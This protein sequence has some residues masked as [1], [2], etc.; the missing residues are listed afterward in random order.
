MTFR[1]KKQH[2]NIAFAAFKWVMAIALLIFGVKKGLLDPSQWMEFI[3]DPTLILLSLAFQMAILLAHTARWKVLND[4]IGS[5]IPF[6]KLYQIQMISH[7]FSI[8]LAG[9]VGADIVR[10]LYASRLEKES[11][12]RSILTIVLDR[13][14]GLGILLLIAF[15]GLVWKSGF[16]PET[17]RIGQAAQFAS[18]IA[19]W[20]ALGLGVLV[21]MGIRF[22][23][24]VFLSSLYLSLLSSLLTVAWIYILGK[25]LGIP[26]LFRDYL[27]MVPLAIIA[28]AI[29]ILPLGIGVGQIAY[30]Q[31]F[32]ILGTKGELGVSLCTLTQF[33]I[34]LFNLIGV[35]YYLKYRK[36]ASNPL[37]N[38]QKYQLPAA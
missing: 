18:N 5:S 4:K 28:S 26:L 31:L 25:Y 37:P 23:G 21:F 15:S 13:G 20:A 9:S 6:K 22:F 10:G 38:K 33:H 17:L 2:K 24:K 1:I 19:P 14:A 12:V 32:Q 29:P 35:F 36:E 27:F 11:G 3:F 30:F 8:F 34:L 7:F 16:L